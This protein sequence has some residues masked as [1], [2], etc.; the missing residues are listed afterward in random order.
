MSVQLN[1]PSK[2]IISSQFCLEKLLDTSLSSSV[3]IF[4]TGRT[5]S[6]KTTLINLLAGENYFC[7][8]GFQD[9]TNEVNLLELPIGLKS[10]D[11]PG[12]CSDD[13]LENYNRAA[14]GIEQLADFDCVE[15][16]T[17]ANYH[18][19]SLPIKCNYR[20]IEFCKTLKPDLIFY[21]FAPDKQF[22][23]CDRQYLIKLLEHYHQVIYVFN[24]FADPEGNQN[25]ASSQNI[26]D[27]MG[28]ITEVHKKYVLGENKEPKI[29]QIN[30]R[31]S[32]GIDKLFMQSCEMLGFE[33]GKIFQ[34]LI[35]YQSIKTPDAYATQVKQEILKLCA[36][37]A[38][39]K[40]T[41][42]D[43]S[44]W[45]AC[46][47][48]WKFLTDILEKPQRMPKPVKQAVNELVEK[49]IVECVERHYEDEIRTVSK[50][51]YKSVPVIN[52][53]YYQEYDDNKPIYKEKTF[54]SE[55]GF[56]EGCGNLLMHGRWESEEIRK[57]C[58]GYKTKTVSRQ[59]WHGKYREEYSHTESVIEK[60]GNQIFKGETY[61]YFKE[62]AITLILVF[63]HII[64]SGRIEQDKNKDEVIVQYNKLSKTIKNRVN[65]WLSFSDVPTQEQ[66]FSLLQPHID[67]LFKSSFDM[68]IKKI[69]S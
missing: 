57:V 63:A 8:T 20:N 65:Q 40:P 35:D 22:L 27:A 9:C 67:S 25:F 45:Q 69:I 5:G 36:Y 60:T 13:E 41:Q 54:Y 28:K 58:I 49:V 17:I 16:L 38:C 53:V 11:L 56:F 46:D 64:A 55:P 23:R 44:L 32:E 7:S 61:H 4:L 52:T 19:D 18:R 30:C 48:L 66:V 29:L 6:G 21:L 1:K 15:N 68:T 47:Q 42:H 24:M 12:V 59:E 39:Q 37:T 26:A 51:I 33:K 10:F 2:S 43:K 3:N 14:L 34:V 62:K 50:D 31:T